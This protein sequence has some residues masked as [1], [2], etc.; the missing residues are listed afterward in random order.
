MR[1]MG[2]I[3]SQPAGSPRGGRQIARLKLLHAELIPICL[4][5]ASQRIGERGVGLVHA[6]ATDQDQLA[7]LARREGGHE[8][9]AG[10]HLDHETEVAM[11]VEQILEQI[12]AMT[13][14][15]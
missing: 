15:V 8:A 14:G 9:H 13:I 12:R 2:G 5:D 10:A 6:D 1:A 3:H 11:H 4:E 7:L